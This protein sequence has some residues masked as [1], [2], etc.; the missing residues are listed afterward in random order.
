MVWGLRVS[1]TLPLVEKNQHFDDIEHNVDRQELRYRLKWKAVPCC[2]A[3]IIHYPDSSSNLW[4]VII[5]T[6]QVYQLS[7]WHKLNQ[8]LERREFAIG[9]HRHDVK[10]L[11][12]IILIHLIEWLENLRNS[13]FPEMIYS[14]ETDIATKCQEKWNLV[15]EEDF[16]FLENLFVE[17]QQLHRYFHILPSHRI[18]LAPRGLL[19]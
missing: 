12:E 6:H 13:P 7:T 16:S 19:L 1:E 9:V 5:G 18:C 2:S 3:S 10:S 17:L 11:L 4:Y 8:G 15:H 14:H